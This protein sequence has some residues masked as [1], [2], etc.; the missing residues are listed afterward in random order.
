MPKQLDIR[1]LSMSQTFL[2]TASCNTFSCNLF[3]MALDAHHKRECNIATCIIRI[4]VGSLVSGSACQQAQQFRVSICVCTA[5][6]PH[7][8]SLNLSPAPFYLLLEC[9]WKFCL[10][11]IRCLNFA[12]LMRAHTWPNACARNPPAKPYH[13]RPLPLQVLAPK[14]PLCD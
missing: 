8:R 12:D 3:W 9:P 2:S 10:Y 14:P 4:S 1:N 5:A 6:A 11:V 7:P 13:C